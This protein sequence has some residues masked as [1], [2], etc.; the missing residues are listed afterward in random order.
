MKKNSLVSIIVPT[1]DRKKQ[2]ERLLSSIRSSKYKNFEIFVIN[3]GSSLSLKLKKNEHII[4]NPTNLGLA[5]ART[6]G[7][8]LANGEFVLFVDDDNVFDEYT[9]ERLVNTLKDDP[10]VIAVG[11]KTYYLS[12][13]KKVWFMGAKMNLWTTKPYFYMSEKGLPNEIPVEILHNCFIVR[14]SVGDRVG[15]F[16]AKLFM[17]GTEY[18]LFQRIKKLKRKENKIV[19]A[20][21]ASC[22]HD[23]PVFSSDLLRS[24]GFENP[25][26]AYYFQRNRGVFLKRYGTILQRMT[27]ALIFIPFFSL[28]YGI[29]F[30]SKKRFDL[31]SEHIRG[32]IDGYILLFRPL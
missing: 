19:I 23:M 15:W 13:P 26:R 6:K 17:N 1:R 11:P 25:K 28:F 14:K 16:D 8:S 9:I 12:S 5:A 3:N 22:W 29:L 27:G 2:L 18:D 31:L 24:M 7:A 30:L 10:S 20:T 4:T 21:N 32:I